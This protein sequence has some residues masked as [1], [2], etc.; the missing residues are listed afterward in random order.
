MK[1]QLLFVW[2]A[3]AAFAALDALGYVT[4]GP[5]VNAGGQD[6]GWINMSEGADLTKSKY[7]TT[8]G[9]WSLA[10]GVF[11]LKPRPGEKGWQRWNHY[12]WSN[13]N[14]GDFEIKFDY[15]I[16]KGGNS[17]FFFR[18]DEKKKLI[19]AAKYGLEVQIFD[20]FGSKKLSDHTSGGLIPGIP[21]LQNAAKP[22]EDWNAMHVIVKDDKLTVILNDVK[23]QDQLDLTKGVLGQRPKTGPIGFQDEALPI[24]VR[25]IRLQDLTK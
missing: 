23:V 14:Y 3:L 19:E 21:P 25:N 4:P 7:W 5:A 1:K 10:D 9:N 12:L 8:E 2:L 16:G 22:I 13:K 20:S 6:T 15:K 17:G 18:V 24:M 11:T